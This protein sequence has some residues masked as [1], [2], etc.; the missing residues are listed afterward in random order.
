MPQE[1]TDEVAALVQRARTGDRAAWEALVDRFTGLVWSVVRSFRFDDAAAADITQTAW[2][3]LVEHL[4]EI[5]DPG[6]V[7]AWLATTTRRE[8]L[9][10]LR[11]GRREIVAPYEDLER[12]DD[13]PPVDTALLD[14]ERDAELWAALAQ[15]PDRCQRLLR[16]LMSS[17]A[18]SYEQVSA[19]LDMP[20]GSIGPTR[21]RCL[22]H[23]KRAL[24]SGITTAT[25]R[26]TC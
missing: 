22:S 21:A 17:P 6:H 18:P 7:G 19:A 2:L 1:Q 13:G 12:V 5:H 16:I 8:C 15:V 11:R 20:M 9:A 10:L 4:D 26:S 3:R 25:P 14:T 23:L 24:E